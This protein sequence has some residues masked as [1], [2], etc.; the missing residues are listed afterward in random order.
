M[1]KRRLIRTVERDR[2][3]VLYSMM[4]RSPKREK[5][6]AGR[7][8]PRSGRND[9]Q[10]D[11]V[12]ATQGL[13]LP[14]QL[15]LHAGGG[16][17]DAIDAIDEVAQLV[18]PARTGAEVADAELRRE[19]QVHPAE[20][21]ELAM[22]RLQRLAIADDADELGGCVAPPGPSREGAKPDRGG[23]ADQEELEDLHSVE[24]A[25]G[26]Q[27]KQQGDQRGDGRDPG[28]D[29]RD[30]VGGE[31]PQRAVVTIVEAEQLGEKRPDRQEDQRP[32]P[33][34][35]CATTIRV[36]R[37]PTTRSASAR[38]RRRVASRHQRP[39]GEMPA[40]WLRPVPHGTTPSRRSTWSRSVARSLAF[41]G[42]RQRSR[43]IG[44]AR[45]K[46]RAPSARQRPLPG[47]NSVCEAML[48]RTSGASWSALLR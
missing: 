39:R 36:A 18:T 11:G 34:S 1:S 6:S 23:H 21:L 12:L 8:S 48:G 4:G 35:I 46:H 28:E 32:D 30:L 43:D 22:H 13:E 19:L 9:A 33:S 40:A 17:D 20:H 5:F 14:D 38:R 24:S 42:E 31:M 37:Q 26:S 41:M 15:A 44:M 27:R 25:R 7:A 45:P 3:Q 29:R 47:V 10:L 16:D 2:S